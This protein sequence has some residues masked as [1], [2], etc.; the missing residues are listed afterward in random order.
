MFEDPKNREKIK[1]IFQ[2]LSEDESEL[3]PMFKRAIK[4]NGPIALYVAT[5][6]KSDITWL[7]DKQEIAL[8]LGGDDALKSITNQLLP[9]EKDKQEGMVFVIFK[10][11]GPLYSIRL[12]KAVLEEVFL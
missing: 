4:E 3:V 6:D 8:M 7:F 1:N 5:K 12:E 2:N 11:I 9:T 10:K